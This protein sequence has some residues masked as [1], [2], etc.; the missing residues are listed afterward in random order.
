MPISS[1]NFRTVLKQLSRKLCTLPSANGSAKSSPTSSSVS[2]CTADCGARR[3]T[4]A[5]GAECRTA[6]VEVKGVKGCAVKS[7]SAVTAMSILSVSIATGSSAPAAQTESSTGY[8]ALQINETTG[9]ILS[10]L[11]SITKKTNNCI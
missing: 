5:L 3:Q 2:F 11:E 10:T 9:N 4:L 8:V 7:D 1:L 6:S